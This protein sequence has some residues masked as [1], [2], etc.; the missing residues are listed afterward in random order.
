MKV[1]SS[2]LQAEQRLTKLW[3]SVNTFPSEGGTTKLF[4]QSRTCG[5]EACGLRAS[6]APEGLCDNYNAAFSF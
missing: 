3:I 6:L 2:R 5:L 1:S 4:T